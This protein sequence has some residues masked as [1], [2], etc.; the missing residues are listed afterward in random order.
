MFRAWFNSKTNTFLHI[1]TD[2]T[3][4]SKETSPHYK[5]KV[6]VKVYDFSVQMM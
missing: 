4:I 1:Q 2:C 3:V 5:T 6:L